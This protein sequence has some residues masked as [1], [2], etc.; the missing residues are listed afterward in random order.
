M[1]L[2]VEIAAG[3]V[4]GVIALAFLGELLAVAGVAVLVG[5]GL[6]A[7]IVVAA[8]TF[9]AVSS[10]GAATFLGLLFLAAAYAY[11]EQRG[12]PGQKRRAVRRVRAHHTATA[13]AVSEPAVGPQDHSDDP[14]PAEEF[15]RAVR[16]P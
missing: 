2:I 1:I 13:A 15:A 16:K 4:L 9:E 5:L 6:L 14:S 3:V 12:Y 10:L 8:A 7:L 11:F